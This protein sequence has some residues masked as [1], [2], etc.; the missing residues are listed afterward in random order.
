MSHQDNSTAVT[1]TGQAPEELGAQLDAL[2]AGHP[3]KG[4]FVGHQMGG[5]QL[6]GPGVTPFGRERIG[7]FSWDG[8]I[9][10]LN[11]LSN[12]EKGR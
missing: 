1:F 3:A 7:E 10:Y 6:F 4:Y 12:F 9:R 5:W 2:P 11:G 8:L